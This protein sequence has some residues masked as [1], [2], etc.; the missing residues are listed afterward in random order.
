MNCTKIKQLLEYSTLRVKTKATWEN[1]DH[2][3][4]V[5]TI[6]ALNK[7]I[8]ELNSKLSQVSGMAHMDI[9]IDAT[10]FADALKAER[11]EFERIRKEANKT[12]R[13]CFEV[14]RALQA[15]L[16]S[17]QCSQSEQEQQQ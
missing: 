13:Q 3:L 9:A 17:E 8:A 10:R 11:I 4:L 12:N 1:R 16:F 5:S 15:D 14:D 7:R 6:G 2:K